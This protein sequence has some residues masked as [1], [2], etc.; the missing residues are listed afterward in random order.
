MLYFTFPLLI[1]KKHNDLKLS[2]TELEVI[3]YVAS[4]RYNVNREAGVKDV[5]MGKNDDALEIMVYGLIAEYAF[6]KK[7][8]IFQDLSSEPR[9]GTYDCITPSGK[10]VDIK[11]TR[12]KNGN[13]VRTLKK[14]NDVDTYVLAVVHDDASVEFVGWIVKEDFIKPENIKDLGHGKTYFLDRKHLNKF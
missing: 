13:L 8:N 12:R 6:C 10:R 7:F 11:A 2:K 14:N 1:L 3:G 4:L 9:S 5:K